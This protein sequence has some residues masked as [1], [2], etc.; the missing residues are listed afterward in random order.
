MATHWGAQP[1]GDGRWRFGLWAPD[2]EEARLEVGG[3]AMPAQSAGQGWWLFEGEA[4]AGDAYRWVIEGTPYPDPAARA[5]IGDVHGPSMLVDPA[6]YHWRHP[7]PG[8]PWHEAI[9]YELHLGTFTEEGTF[10]AAITE[11]P[12][13]ADLGVTMI[14]IMPVAQ[15]EGDRGWGYDGVLPFAPHPAYGTPDEMRALVDAAHSHGIAVMLDVVYNHFGPSGNYLGAWCPSFFH[16]ERASPWGA[17]IAFEAPAVREYFIANALHWL[18]E[19]RLDGL[20][21]DAVHA[22]EDHSET[23]FLD[24]LAARIRSRDFGRPIHLV[25]ED[26]R[27]LAR[28]FTVDA[29]YDGTW[30]DDWHHAVHCLLTGEEESYYAPFAVDPVA[31]IATA[32]ADGYVEQGQPRENGEDTPRGEPSTHLPRTAFVNFLGNHDQVGNRARGERLHHL[33]TDRHAYRVMTALTLLTPFTPMLFMGDEFLTDAPFQFFVDFKGDL[34]DAVRKGRAQEFARFSSF[35]GEVPDPVAPET[36]MASSIGR[37]VRADQQEH[38]A[39]VRELL[40]LR[41]THV[42]PLLA[43]NPQP[44]AAVRQEGSGI[45]AQWS[46]APGTLRLRAELG[47]ST[48]PFESLSGPILLLADASSPFALSMTV[49]PE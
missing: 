40:D 30:N 9:V 29:P 15:F 32:L 13:L 2:A 1:L 21:L 48:T 43:R 47:G 37:P 49:S 8:R 11:L 26:E 12:R 36:F 34:A 44:I 33:A 45:G 41:R 7:W 28:Y 14:E 27:N 18:D 16:P 31:D 38:E 42:T 20:R 4:A 22:I 24:E 46:F 17:G 6:T 10:A 19:Y 3:M 5:Q 25:T 39:F 23:H 35:G